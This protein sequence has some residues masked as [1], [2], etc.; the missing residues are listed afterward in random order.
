MKRREFIGLIGGAAAA[1]PIGVT[2]HGRVRRIGYLTPLSANA[3]RNLE[4]CFRDALREQGWIEGQN[5]EFEYRR[6]EGN[7]DQISG[8]ADELVRLGP[9]LIVAAGTPAAQVL[10]KATSE[11]PVVFVAVSDPVASRIVA[12]LARPGRN[13]TGVSNFLP[14]TSGKLLQLLK[15]LVPQLLHVAVLRDANNYGKTLE[16]RELQ[17]AGQTLGIRI[18]PMELRTPD[19]IEP[20]FAV[21]AKE[22]PNALVALQDG[23]TFANRQR[24]VDSA[25]TIKLPA[26]YQIRKFAEAGGL[27]SYGLNYCEHLKRAGAYVDKILRPQRRLASLCRRSCKWLPTR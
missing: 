24:I 4:D 12:S 14:A 26:I 6:F 3:G 22:P 1:W 7:T 20:A 21:M 17:I 18:D 13:V 15:Q 11:I 8:L 5:V 23:I 19:D 16:V 10:Q 27:M 9:D 25:S 2:A